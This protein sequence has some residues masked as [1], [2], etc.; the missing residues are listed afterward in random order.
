[1][2]ILGPPPAGCAGFVGLGVV[3]PWLTGLV[4][5]GNRDFGFCRWP[6]PQLRNSSK[7]LLRHKTPSARPQGPPKSLPR[8]PKAYVR[9]QNG[10]PTRGRS[11]TPPELRALCA[12]SARPPNSPQEAATVLAP[13][14][15][16]PGAFLQAMLHWLAVGLDVGRTWVAG[17]SA[18]S[19]PKTTKT[20]HTHSADRM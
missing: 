12:S 18:A 20:T 10:I 11:K 14:G 13:L 19:R 9:L 7:R 8:A 1:M 6:L 2:W 17:A 16:R 3:S 4:G 15:L 5:L